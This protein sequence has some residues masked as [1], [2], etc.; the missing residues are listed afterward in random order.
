M[1]VATLQIPIP[2]TERMP[3]P[4]L[5]L[6]GQHNNTEAQW[7]WSQSEWRKIIHDHKYSLGA[8]SLSVSWI[9]PPRQCFSPVM[10]YWTCKKV[11]SRRQSCSFGAGKQIAEPRCHEAS[12]VSEVLPREPISLSIKMQETMDSEIASA[13][14]PEKV[15]VVHSPT[16]A[17]LCDRRTLM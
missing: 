11:K 12:T 17:N 14:C 8:Q 6:P 15:A 4:L 3:K 5:H 9:L 13:F 7:T 1:P 16:G 10:Q 2:L